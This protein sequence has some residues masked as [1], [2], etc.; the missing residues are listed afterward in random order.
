MQAVFQYVRRTYAMLD[1]YDM[2]GS[3]FNSWPEVVWR[4]SVLQFLMDMQLGPEAGVCP[5]V[6]TRLQ[7]CGGVENTCLNACCS[8]MSSSEGAGL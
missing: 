1:D 8:G 4:R 5:S 3:G 7:R 2:W 6:T